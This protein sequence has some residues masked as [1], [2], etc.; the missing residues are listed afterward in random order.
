MEFAGYW[1]S[2][3]ALGTLFDLLRLNEQ[4]LKELIIEKRIR[5]QLM[6]QMTILDGLVLRIILVWVGKTGMPSKSGMGPQS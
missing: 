2:T 4:G 1:A 3:V 5:G 6:Y